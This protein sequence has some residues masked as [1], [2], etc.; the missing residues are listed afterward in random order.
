[1]TKT[2]ELVYIDFEETATKVFKQGPVALARPSRRSAA[3]WVRRLCH[4]PGLTKIVSVHS[5][6]AISGAARRSHKSRETH[7]ANREL[8]APTG[9]EPAHLAAEEPKSTASTNSATGPRRACTN[10]ALA[11]VT[12]HVAKAATRDDH[13]AENPRFSAQALWIRIKAPVANVVGFES[14]RP[15][16]RRS[17]AID[18]AGGAFSLGLAAPR[19]GRSFL[20][21]GTSCRLP[22]RFRRG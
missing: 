6:G 13:R 1:M 7:G 2:I 16:H 12:K 15:R 14:L 11:F 10:T 21:A 4:T 9:L 17:E 19:R 18:A 3:S 22:R 8:V 20:R 5:E